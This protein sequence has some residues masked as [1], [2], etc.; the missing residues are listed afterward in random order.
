M[1]INFDI[2]YPAPPFCCG[3]WT[4]SVIAVVFN[5]G[6]FRIFTTSFFKKCPNCLGKI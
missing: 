4:F 2:C 6:R 3:V 5:I 1:N